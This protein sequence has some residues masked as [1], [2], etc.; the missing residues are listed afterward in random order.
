MTQHPMTKAYVKAFVANGGKKFKSKF[1]MFTLDQSIIFGY[2]AFIFRIQSAGSVP[3]WDQ[4]LIPAGVTSLYGD[5]IVMIQ[6]PNFGG[7]LACDE[8]AKAEYEEFVSIVAKT[9]GI[10]KD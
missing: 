5:E 4:D 10:R 2:R 6:S 8:A 7:W 3:S 9:I 1:T